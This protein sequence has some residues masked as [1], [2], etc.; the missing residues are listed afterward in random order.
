[1]TA[2]AAMISYDWLRVLLKYVRQKQLTIVHVQVLCYFS[3]L[4]VFAH[5]TTPSIAPKS[6]N[7]Y[8]RTFLH[9]LE[10]VQTSP[11]TAFTNQVASPH[12]TAVVVHMESAEQRKQRL[13]AMRQAAEAVEGDDAPTAMDHQPTD[14]PADAE[15]GG[16]PPTL[17][18]RNYALRDEKID[19]EK[20]HAGGVGAG[21]RLGAWWWLHVK[22]RPTSRT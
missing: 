1:M 13:K 12:P 6:L 22:R 8:L 7:I 3:R 17:K 9:T 15:N 18:F 11:H 20:V 19:H 21:D 5:N 14:A 16:A 2:A 10:R 4:C